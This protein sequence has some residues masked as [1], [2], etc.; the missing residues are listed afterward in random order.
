[1]YSFFNK[2]FR[3]Y[4]IRNPFSSILK[5][6]YSWLLQTCSSLYRIMFPKPKPKAIQD[7]LMAYLTIKKQNF[8]RTYKKTFSNE[9]INTS[10]DTCFYS[11]KD[12]FNTIMDKDNLIEKV[13]RTR[14]LYETTPRG[15]II[16]YYDVF[17]QGFAYYSDMNNIPYFI[18]NAVAMKYVILFNCRDFFIDNQVTPESEPSPF[19]KIYME[20]PK[21]ITNELKTK[22]ASID[23]NLLVKYKTYN[24][25]KCKDKNTTEEPKKEPIRNV[26]INQGKIYNFSF[27]QKPKKIF[28]TNNF[29]SEFTPIFNGESNLQNAVLSYKDYKNRVTF[30]QTAVEP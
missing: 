13:W 9:N 1:M 21:K 7:P 6:G 10:I 27:I 14:I 29:K 24:K 5:F 19:I 16:M 28:T 20:E 17:K 2:T 25:A 4:Q 26:F 23:S 22:P 8:M 12:F 11:K 3:K 18:L 30:A 15:N